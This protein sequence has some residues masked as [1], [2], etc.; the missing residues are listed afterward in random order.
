MSI[1]VVNED[2][3]YNFDKTWVEIPAIILKNFEQSVTTWFQGNFTENS[4]LKLHNSK[5]NIALP[6]K[7][8]KKLRI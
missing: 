1:N 3:N 7:K 2:D 6:K 4:I 8:P 5:K